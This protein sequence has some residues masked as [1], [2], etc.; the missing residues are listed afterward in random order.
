VIEVADTGIGLDLDRIP[1]G[2][3]APTAESGRGLHVIRACTDGMELRARRPHGLTVR[4]VKVLAW[5]ST[6]LVRA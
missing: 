5:K 6:G 3:P 4:M 1:T 2:R